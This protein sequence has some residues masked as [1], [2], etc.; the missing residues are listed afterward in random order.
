MNNKKIVY[1]TGCLGFIGSYVTRA[2]LAK[3]WYVRGV[4]KITYAANT[5]LLKEFKSNNKFTFEYP[6]IR[7]Y[8]NTFRNS[9]LMIIN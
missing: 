5:N 4:D 3:G 8:L 9:I 2:C 1:V 6:F 7:R